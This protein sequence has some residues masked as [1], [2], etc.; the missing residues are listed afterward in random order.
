MCVWY[1]WPYYIC[2]LCGCHGVQFVSAHKFVRIRYYFATTR[3]YIAQHNRHTRHIE[4]LGSRLDG[5]RVTG[6]FFWSATA[7]G[8]ATGATIW[9]CTAE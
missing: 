8:F 3:T 7:A 6:G 5:H 4:R 2:R 1:L 9:Q